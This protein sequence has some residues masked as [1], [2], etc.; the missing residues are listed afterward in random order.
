[1]RRIISLALCMVMLIST[2][3]VVLADE[4]TE[5]VYNTVSVEFSDNIGNVE[6]LQ[7]MVKN[8]NVYASAEELGKRLGYDVGISEEY[9]SIYNQDADENVPYGLT[10]FYYDSTKVG[11]MLFAQMV[12]SY[13]APFETIKNENGVWIPLEY[14]LL[15]LNSSMLIVENTILIDIPSKNIVDILMDI[16]K[17]N[18]KYLFD[19]QDDIG[20]SKHNED[21]MRKASLVVTMFSGLLN[22]DGDS[23]VQFVQNFALDSSSYDSKYGEELAMLLCTYSSDELEQEVKEMKK[24]MS[25]FNGK[26]ALGKS[27]NAID[28]ELDNNIGDLLKTSNRFK[29][30]IDEKNNASILAYNKSYRA[31]E[32]ACDKAGFFSNATEIYAQVGKGVSEATSFLDKFFTVAEIVGFASEFQNQDKFAVNTISEFVENSHSMSVMSNAMKEGIGNYTDALQTNI[33]IYSALRYL[34]ENYDE[35][36]FEA[37]DLVSSLGLPAQLMLIAWDVMSANV[38]FYK[39]GLNNTDSFLLSMYASVFQAEAFTS[40][41]IHRNSTFND[42]NTI[43]PENLYKVSQY[44]YLYLKSC[45]ITRD[46]AL[47]A[48]NEETKIRVVD[49]IEYQ[50]SI[51]REIAGYMVQLKNADKSNKNKCYGFLLEDNEE[52]LETYSVNN[53]SN[54]IKATYVSV[55]S[56]AYCD[57]V[58]DHNYSH[59]LL[60][61]H[62]PQV[63]LG[64]NLANDINKKIFEELNSILEK[65]VYSNMEDVNY[66]PTLSEMAY[67]WGQSDEIISIIVETNQ[68]AWAWTGYYVYN[69]SSETGKEI[70]IEELLAKYNLSI[71]DF[72]SL[73]SETI[74]KYWE[75]RSD[76]IS[77][78]GQEQYNLLVERSLDEENIK[79]SVPYINL[80]GELCIVANIYSPAGADSYLHLLNTVS[81]VEENYI[82]CLIE[83]S[84]ETDTPVL[85]DDSDITSEVNAVSVTKQEI[86]GEWEIDIDYTLNCSNI[87]MRDYY[88]S[89]FYDGEN[90]MVFNS[91]GSFRYCVAWC[92]GNG[93]YHVD[94]GRIILRLLA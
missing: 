49:L 4:S 7:V 70:V 42:V 76:L 52:Y 81:G 20:L 69:I 41:Q 87:S 27:I 29:S 22:M 93:I 68:T 33:A 45:Y 60:C 46:A 67:S 26:G 32:N 43:T 78:I 19:W 48:L 28:K 38:P 1:M 31:L 90:K 16:L 65:E 64:N 57:V 91:D 8:D 30:K 80:N 53:L 94:D 71:Y 84:N 75:Q 17:K 62:I 82:E 56:D 88:G 44:C 40:Y 3:N 34:L 83:H 23:W 14:S 37:T 10:V 36:V 15:L 59:E 47:G 11:H 77:A 79:S 13:E 89:S 5:E 12:D 74:K 9:V 21:T 54:S 66:F 6:T 61:Y 50:N 51:N 39:E 63:N 24:L 73:A 72:Y 86:V 55:V 18:Q 58:Y 25:H 92:Y 2:S 35:L 85:I